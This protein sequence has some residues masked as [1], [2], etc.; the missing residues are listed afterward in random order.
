MAE[1]ETSP[2]VELAYYIDKAQDALDKLVRNNENRVSRSR[3]AKLAKSFLKAAK[4]SVFGGDEPLAMDHKSV[5]MILSFVQDVA[6]GKQS[7]AVFTLSPDREFLIESVRKYNI[8]L[9]Y[10]ES[11]KDSQHPMADGHL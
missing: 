8:K 10:R 4:Q 3:Q 5:R 2:G 9:K 1:K 11:D 6:D 7:A